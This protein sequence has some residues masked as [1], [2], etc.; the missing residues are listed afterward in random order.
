MRQYVKTVAESV[1]RAADE[2]GLPVLEIPGELAY[3][4][5]I[6]NVMNRTKE[7]EFISLFCL[8]RATRPRMR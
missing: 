5:I 3:I 4:D 6:V 1:K 8:V 7:S 2:V